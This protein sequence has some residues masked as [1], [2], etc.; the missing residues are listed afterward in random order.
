MIPEIVNKLAPSTNTVASA[1]RVSG[2]EMP[3]AVLPPVMV[4]PVPE[5]VTAVAP[6]IILATV[7]FPVTVIPLVLVA[8]VMSAE[9]SIRSTTL[10]L[11]ESMVTVPEPELASKYTFVLVPGIAS[12]VAVPPEVSAQ[13]LAASLQ[14]PVP[15][16]Q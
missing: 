15:P 5:K 16:T 13:W 3:V 6:E 2:A 1:P 10:T 7:I 14:S 4:L 11:A 8:M 12:A 9:D